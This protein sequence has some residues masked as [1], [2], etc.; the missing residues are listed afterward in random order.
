VLTHPDLQHLFLNTLAEV[1][2]TAP[3]DKGQ[4]IG[5]L[6]RL[7]IG[8]THVL[9]VDFKTN[10]IV[11]PS[12]ADVPS[13]LLAQMGAYF[14]A[15][16]QIYPTKQVNIAI[17]WTKTAQLMPLDHDMMSAALNRATIS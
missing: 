6:D 13:G 14:A 2:I 7:V 17:L 1:P 10:T 11:P 5:I 16:Q 15:L 12:A 4:I 9:A 8:E 3:L